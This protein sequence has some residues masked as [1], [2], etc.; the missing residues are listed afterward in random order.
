R[1][2]RTAAR[3]VRAAVD[4]G[5]LRARRLMLV[6]TEGDLAAYRAT[7][8]GQGQTDHLVALLRMAPAPIGE[9]AESRAALAAPL[10]TAHVDPRNQAVDDVLLLPSVRR[11]PVLNACLDCFALLPV[12]IHLD[13]FSDIEAIGQPRIETVGPIIALTLSAAPARPVAVIG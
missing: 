3:A 8:T 13:A 5:V 6:G 7:R 1:L 2:E 11:G 9:D 10:R 4:R 12:G